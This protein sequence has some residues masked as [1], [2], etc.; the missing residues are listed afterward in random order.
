MDATQVSTVEQTR[1]QLLEQV[2]TLPAGVLQELVDFVTQLHQREEAS[3][4]EE[5]LEE[6][7]A[8]PYQDLQDLIGC[9]EGPTDLSTN[10]KAYL[11]EGF[12]SDCDH[13]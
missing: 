5:V 13:R 7:A 4:T 9:G 2:Q 8:N 12:G 10:Y 6:A 11:R 1:Q 3:E